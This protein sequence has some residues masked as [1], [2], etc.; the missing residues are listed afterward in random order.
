MTR[1]VFPAALFVALLLAGIITV[2]Q[3]PA[4]HLQVRT[5]T[6]AADVVQASRPAD[7]ASGLQLDALDRTADVC[8][9]FYQFACGGWVA[10]NP[11]PSDR[12]SWGRFEELQER[13]NDTLH[14]I[15]EAA[16]AG[17]EPESKKI[18][19]YYASCLDER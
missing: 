2:A 8:T 10:K 11:V 4:A 9:D 16:A 12:A 7:S 3:T 15:L 18:G 6:T 1:R 19:D 5:T 17:R 14:S 13:N